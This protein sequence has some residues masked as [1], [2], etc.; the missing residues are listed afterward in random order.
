MI[1]ALTKKGGKILI[2][3]KSK[4]ITFKWRI[5]LIVLSLFLVSVSILTV[6][7]L[8]TIN[9]K[10]ERELKS[11]GVKLAQQI[12]ERIDGGKRIEGML[13]SIIDRKIAEACSVLK[14]MDIETM[15]NEK[16]EEIVKDF[17]VSEISVIGPDRKIDFSNVPANI[18]WEYPV[19]HKMDTV[20]N[21]KS[22]TYLEEPRENPLDGKIYKFGGISLNNGYFVQAGVSLELI[23]EAKNDFEIQRILDGITKDEGVLYAVQ[24]DK[25][26][27]AIAG[28][29]EYVGTVYDDEVTKSAAMNGVTASNAWFDDVLGI[30]IYDVQ[31]PFYDDG[32]HIGSICVG[33]SLESMMK[34]QRDIFNT[35]I[36]VSIVIILLAA[37]VLYFVIGFSMKPIKITA[38]HIERIA[39]GDFTQSVSQNILNYNDEIGDIAK[40]VEK[41]QAELK[42]LMRNVKDSAIT[43][44]D[45]SNKLADITYQ[46]N[47][48]MENVA[49][50]VE[51]IALSASEQSKDVEVVAMSTDDL[52]GKINTSAELINDAVNLTDEMS[53]LG[54]EAKVVISQ[55]YNKTE[56]SKEKSR[57]VYTIVEEV[58]NSTRNAESIIKLITEIAQQTN[59]LAL[60]ASI[61]AA[62]AGEAG[63]GFAVVAEEIR[64]LAESTGSA[65][66][67]INGIIND[68]QIRA[69]N[70]VNTMAEVNEITASQNE[71]IDDT[72]NIFNKLDSKLNGLL[73]KIEEIDKISNDITGNKDNIIASIQSISAITE[74]NTAGTQEV[75]A[76]TEE[77]LASIEE[78]VSIAETSKELAKKL[79]KDIEKFKLD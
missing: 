37:I 20:F 13:Q 49:E 48:A 41:M 36:T 24:I 57:E 45:S 7:S 74:E 30:N 6:V 65:I 32:E 72:G 34:A 56:T 11:N 28:T 10:L 19:G 55:L 35:S 16:I 1:R 66:D 47:Q 75:S 38:N 79:E 71:S 50:S 39:K 58:D 2:K 63:K 26:G 23:K 8:K 69:I 15:T 51:Q 61:E 33:L 31:I 29:E 76:S 59:L 78:I 42:G 60:N 21:G 9:D 67:D 44:V 43:I 5:I 12:V 22:N 70:A 4:K 64:K 54:D 53:K 25:T 73:L 3:K 18:D 40:S 14:Y 77:Q 62:R 52:G 68:I 17:G 27:L 46:S